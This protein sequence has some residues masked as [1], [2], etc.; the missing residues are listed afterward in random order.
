MKGITNASG[1]IPAGGIGTRQLADKAVT[2]AKIADKAISQLYTATIPAEGWTNEAAPYIAE[3]TI[4]GILSSDA[5]DIDLIASEDFTVAEP[6]I[7]A[8]GYVYKGVTKA[9]AISFYATEKPAVA[10]PIQIR[11]VRK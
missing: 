10:L 6:Q 4:D 8:W 5:P 3:V 11:A 2:A 7:E 9:G 1:G